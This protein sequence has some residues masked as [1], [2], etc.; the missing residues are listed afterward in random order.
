MKTMKS[1]LPPKQIIQAWGD[2]STTPK[3]GIHDWSFFIRLISYAIYSQ[4][5]PI[6]Y[7]MYSYISLVMDAMF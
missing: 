6:T 2:T 5:K 1:N 3:Q 4:I 7:A